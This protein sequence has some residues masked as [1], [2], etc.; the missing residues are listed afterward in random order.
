MINNVCEDIIRIFNCNKLI[1][2]GVYQGDSF[3]LLQ[4]WM[5]K[6]HQEFNQGP[7]NQGIKSE[8][9]RIYEVECNKQYFDSYII[10]KVQEQI[11]VECSNSDSVIWLKT[12]ID[13]GEFDDNDSCFYFLDSHQHNSPNPEPLR[14]ELK[15]LCRLKNKPI[16]SIDDWAVPGK[17]QD[18][19]N[20]NQ[21]KDLIKNRTD[22]IYYSKYHNFHGKNSCFVFLDRY[23]DEL[24]PKL[25]NLDLLYEKI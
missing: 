8:K 13:N 9:Y 25:V 7:W 2:T 22:V 16:I 12:N 20:T 23:L 5:I 14:D 3:I 1:E 17:Y 21:I 19:Y 11:N 4:S 18:I 24:K 15:Q 6:L 10:P